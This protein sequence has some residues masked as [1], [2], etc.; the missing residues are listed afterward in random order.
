MGSGDIAATFLTKV[1]DGGGQL[2]AA[3][4]FHPGKE[5]PAPIE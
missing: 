5:S 2:H 4:S 1:L 3:A